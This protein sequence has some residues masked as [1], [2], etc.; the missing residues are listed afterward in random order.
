MQGSR[1]IGMSENG[2]DAEISKVL[3]E[4]A[5]NRRSSILFELGKKDLKT[6]QIAKFLDMTLTEAFRHL[7]R[8]D[9]ADLVEKKP[10]GAYRITS[11]GSLAT[12]FLSGFNFILKNRKYFLEHD[13]S[14]LPYE[15]ADRI[16]ELSSGEFC[17]GV[18]DSFNRVRQ[19]VFEAEKFI[20]VMADQVDSSH[21]QVTNE[22]VSKG[23]KFRFI[24]QQEYAREVRIF[25]EVEHLKERRYMERID[26]A[27]MINE[28]G[29]FFALRGIN[30]VIDYSGFFST[31]EKFRKWCT[32]LFNY[33]WERAERWY[34]GIQIK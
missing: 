10:N 22:K 6:Q 12:R 7:Q 11:I 30:G 34:P 18:L 9:E 5:S 15:L 24:M 8:L 31:D 17:G 16:G 23:L 2:E 28:K 19:M 14:R 21:I 4:L 1:V 25:P 3:F 33:Y 13:L 27:T 29:A 20:L 32:D 26:V